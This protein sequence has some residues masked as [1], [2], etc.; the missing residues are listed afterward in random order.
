[1]V[2]HKFS[3]LKKPNLSHF[4]A[5]PKVGASRSP[6]VH[7]L[8]FPNFWTSFSLRKTGRSFQHR[9]PVAGAAWRAHETL[10]LLGG[11]LEVTSCNWS[12]DL[13]S[14]STDQSLQQCN[15]NFVLSGLRRFFFPGIFIFE[16]SSLDSNLRELEALKT[17]FWM[18]MS[19]VVREYPSFDFSSCLVA[20]FCTPRETERY[21]R[22][23]AFDG[24]KDRI[25]PDFRCHQVWC[26]NSYWHWVPHIWMSYMSYIII[27][28]YL[29]NPTF[30]F[31]DFPETWHVKKM[32]P[33]SGQTLWG[34]GAGT[35]PHRSDRRNMDHNISDRVENWW[36]PFLRVEC[37]VNLCQSNAVSLQGYCAVWKDCLIFH[38]AIISAFFFKH[39]PKRRLPFLH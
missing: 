2:Y 26:C 13:R 18:R 29:R 39:R 11:K 33:G 20:C 27:Y 4:E 7:P 12:C 37:G 5:T 23:G 24:R 35:K 10:G 16:K 17:S 19:H 9:R 1:M 14:I 15:E 8:E 32:T 28:I 30:F 34:S 22:S 6:E 21:Q 36:P 38:A 3:W 25:N 31:A